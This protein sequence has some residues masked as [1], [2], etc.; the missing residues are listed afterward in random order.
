ML[1]IVVCKSKLSRFMEFNTEG[2]RDPGTIFCQKPIL[3]QTMIFIHTVSRKS[4]FGYYNKRSPLVLGITQKR[5]YQ[6]KDEWDF[7]H[8]CQF[9][10]L[11]IINEHP[12][13]KNFCIFVDNL[14]TWL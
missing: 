6:K 1:K 11:E 13:I 3:F 2:I 12:E 4:L 5:S 14:S 9:F 7:F 10:Y 8:C